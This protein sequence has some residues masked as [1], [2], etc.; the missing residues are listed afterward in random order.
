MLKK[1]FAPID[2][3]KGKIYKVIIIFM[4]PIL[5]SYIFQQ[6][7]TLTDA[8]IVGQNLSASEVNGVNDVNSLTYIVLQFA[9]GCS[10]G[11]SVISSAKMGEKDQDGVRKSFLA[12][13]ILG[14]IISVILTIIATALIDPLL[15]IIGLNS[16]TGGATYQAA[17]TYIL[18]IFLGTICQVAYNQICSL[19]RSI[20]DSLTP[21]LFLIASTILNI[22]LDL[23]FI[24]VFKFGVAGAAVATIIAQ[25]LSAAL[26]YIYTFIKYPFLRFKRS[27]LKLDGKFLFEHL[28]L[29]LPLAFQFSILAI[30]LITLQS[31]IIKFDT[32]LEGVVIENG[33][34]ELAYGAANKIT[35][36]LMTPLNALGTA[37]LSYCG[38]NYG[39]KLY[40]RV[41]KGIATS[42]LI[43]FII[44]IIVFAIALLLLIDNAYL[45]LIY[46]ADSIN[47]ETSYLG[48]FN[49]F[50]TVPFFP[51]VGT[52]F[53]L[54]CSLQGIQK[55][56]LPFLAG[57]GELV[58]RTVVC[59]FGPYIFVSTISTSLNLYE[60]PLPYIATALADPF[61]WLTADIFLIIG[62][63][64]YIYLPYR[65]QKKER[66][67]NK[68]V[69]K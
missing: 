29:G 50:C 43:M 46:S 11:F 67:N 16:L 22:C 62:L 14:F 36:F 12:Q 8:I 17:K 23:L 42:F 39:A 33:P 4:L 53:I 18:I 37:M 60:S 30:G 5:L 64:I 61:A 58:A 69:C 10:A 32:T 56:I 52:I 3:T 15:S 21:L 44:Y 24:V 59:L 47:E 48:K 45:K 41:N 28:K 9:Y 68:K 26:C 63:I 27:D 25:G 40:K 1:L 34:A 20:G 2:M 38:Q 31:T 6:I 55:P 66:L 54:R 35:N 51:L 13:V 7:Y 57:V 49:I 19:L 65:K